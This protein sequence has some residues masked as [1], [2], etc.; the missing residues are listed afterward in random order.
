M[1]RRPPRST[2]TVTL[3]PYT[4]LVR[5]A[6]ERGAGGLRRL[7]K[8]FAGNAVGAAGQ[9]GGGQQD[10]TEPPGDGSGRGQRHPCHRRLP[11]AGGP[12]D[13]PI[14]RQT[15][16]EPVPSAFALACSCPSASFRYSSC[17]YPSLRGPSALPCPPPPPG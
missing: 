13:S 10:Q 16:A 8:A 7:V 15:M 2:R 9:Q 3:S 12:A 6:S 11:S 5:S 4:T 1:I 14:A 17:C